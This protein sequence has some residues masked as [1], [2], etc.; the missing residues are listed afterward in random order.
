LIQKLLDESRAARRR[1]K[2]APQMRT[3][4]PA[5]VQLLQFESQATALRCYQPTLVA[6]IFQTAGYAAAV[7]NFGNRDL[8]EEVRTARLEVRSHRYANVFG[9]S[10]PP[11]YL[12]ILDESVVW[13]QIGGA[14]AMMEQL[15]HLLEL[16]RHG[17]I[18]VRISPFEVPGPGSLIGS[19]LIIDLGERDAVLYR[20]SHQQDEIVQTA[21]EVD[22]HRHIFEEMW[23]RAL[24]EDATARL[25]ASRSAFVQASLDRR[26]T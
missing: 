11:Q 23:Q 19:F 25:I 9:G 13:R 6:G 22:R 4:T 18:L 26:H 15:D 21:G 5:T 17:R 14:A 2:A 1:D 8:S 3:L 7:M 16:V 10:N 20:E 12:L 24:G